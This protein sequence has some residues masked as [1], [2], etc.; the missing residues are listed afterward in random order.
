V[1]E[2]V[3]IAIS[4]GLVAACGLFVAAEFAF[5]TVDR[6]TVERGAEDGDAKAKGVMAALRSLSTQLSGAQ[7]GITLTNLLIG[8][9]AEPAIASL[10]DSPLQSAG[11]PSAAVTGVAVIIALTLATGVTMVFGEL[12]PKNLAIT[13]PYAVSRAVQR[14][15]RL[16]TAVSGP[17]I[18][19]M[20]G[21]AN[22]ILLR[23]GIEPQE[24]LAS[25]R[26]A[27]ELASLVRR[28]AK[29]GTLELST[30]T[31]LER[32]LIF[33]ERTA[34]DVMTPRPR[35]RV[36]SRDASAMAVV[37]AARQ[38][39]YS[40]F[41]VTGGTPDEIVGIVHVKQAVS[42]PLG[43]RATTSIETIMAPP[44]LVPSSV[45]LDRLLELL[46]E[47]GLQI[48]I[49]VDEFGDVDGVVTLEDVVEEIVGEVVDEHDRP[50]PRVRRTPAGDWM[51]SG[52]LRPDEVGRAV[53]LALPEGEEYETIAG[54]LA[55]R[56]ERMP[57]IGDD[58]EIDVVD[59]DRRPHR[60]RLTVSRMD[61][62]RVDRVLLRA[63]PLPHE[64]E[65]AG[66]E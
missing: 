11:V 65:E 58:V 29:E 61:G 26:S 43:A 47:G 56:L 64:E 30:A 15:M 7:V 23:L 41:P 66:D 54:L 59:F 2:I 10:I 63:D 4:L 51:L 5:V 9:L 45:G 28:S 49:V 1:T 36:L 60:V 12:V 32:S 57:A 44:T 16:F 55:E 37:E 24:E 6:P 20:N 17:V 50:D 22:R 38:T 25:A 46:R 14:P 31:L 33:G 62:L 35:M 39:G 42:V 48:A 52:L 34:S 18:T 40:R 21:A 27:Q 53:G 3:F 13:H 19:A 8:F